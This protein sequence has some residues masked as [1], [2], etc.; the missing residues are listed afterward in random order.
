MEY[1]GEIEMCYGIRKR[2]V[3]VLKKMT[4]YNKILTAWNTEADARGDTRSGQ[5]AW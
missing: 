5:A 2:L 4:S 3:Y 1:V